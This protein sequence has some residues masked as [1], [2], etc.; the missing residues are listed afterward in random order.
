MI[1]EIVGSDFQVTLAKPSP[2]RADVVGSCRVWR[3]C[4]EGN[5]E[6][7]RPGKM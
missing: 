2:S 1:S 3:R 7:F 5:V 4:R 6:F